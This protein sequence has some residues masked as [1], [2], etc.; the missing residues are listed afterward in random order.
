[1]PGPKKPFMFSLICVF[2]LIIL[3]I[4]ISN[5]GSLPSLHYANT[6]SN[7]L[8]FAYKRLLPHLPTHFHLTPLASPFAGTKKCPQ[9]QA[10]ILPLI[11]DKPILCYLCSWSH[12]P[13][14]VYSL[15]GSLVPGSSEVSG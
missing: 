12:G 2:L 3:F 5:V 13:T 14:H 10:P 11:P 15:I 9:D 1:M 4:Y 8:H 6:P 7:S